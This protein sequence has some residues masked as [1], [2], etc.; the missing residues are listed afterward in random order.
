MLT[1]SR[2]GLGPPGQDKLGTLPWRAP[3]SPLSGLAGPPWRTTS[4]AYRDPGGLPA[5]H[6]A[7]G[8]RGRGQPIDPD[9]PRS[10]DPTLDSP[11]P[12][13]RLM[14]QGNLKHG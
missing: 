11:P 14:F 9:G 4:L 13:R 2:H 3:W 12:S 7:G 10:A 1:R 6:Q 5:V 8:P